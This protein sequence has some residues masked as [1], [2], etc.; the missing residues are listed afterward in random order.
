MCLIF[1]QLSVRCRAT[2]R[3]AESQNYRESAKSSSSVKHHWIERRQKDLKC[4]ACGKDAPFLQCTW[5]KISYHS[6]SE[7]LQRSH[8]NA[9][10]HLGIHANLIIPPSWIVKIADPVS[11]KNGQTRS[12]TFF[13]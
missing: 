5:C 7:C 1:K 8:Y 9:D 11:V 2:F 13:S 4:N 6:K 3:E 10:C 12:P